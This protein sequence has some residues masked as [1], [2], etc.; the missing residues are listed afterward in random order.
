DVKFSYERFTEVSPNQNALKGLVDTVETPDSQTVVFKL[1]LRY[2]P[3]PVQIA[4]ATEALWLFPKE[5]AGYDPTKVLIGTGPWLFDKETP[6]VGTTYNRNPNWWWQGRPFA[7]TFQWIVIPETAQY[8]AQFVAKRVDQYAPTSINQEILEVRKQTPDAD[9]IKR[10]VG[11]GFSMIY[12]SGQDPDSP[13]RDVRVRRAVSMALDR[14][15]LLDNASNATALEAAGIPVEVSWSNAIVAPGWKKWWIDPQDPSFAEGQW[16]KYNVQEA[17]ALLAAAGYPSGFKTEFHFTPT[18]YGQ[19]F[20]TWSE[21]LIELFKQIGLELDVKVDDYTRVYFPEVFT[22]G[23][24]KGMAW[25]PQ[26]GFQDVDGIIYN[27]LHP[28]GT[29]NHSHVNK[30]GGT[31]FQDGGRLTAMVEA[32]RV[33]VDEGKRQQIIADIQRYASEQMIYVPSIGTANFS[34]FTLSW[35]WLRNTR[36]YNSTTYAIGTEEYAHWWVDEERR[37]QLGG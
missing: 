13:F 33:E 18:R 4:S 9:I 24:F 23:N 15:G 30:P 10:Q 21:A 22:K 36:A 26:S 25:G 2:A 1:K 12:F 14:D 16:Y 3:F 5:A 7:N 28:N 37:Q 19:N 32:Q 11:T 17:K 27:M 34:G 35:P 20:D 6:S 8:L 29:R 31:L